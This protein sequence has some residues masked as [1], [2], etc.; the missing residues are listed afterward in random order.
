MYMPTRR[1]HGPNRSLRAY[2]L[3]CSRNQRSVKPLLQKVLFLYTKNVFVPLDMLLSLT[4]SLVDIGVL[5]RRL[6][7]PV[8]GVG[9]SVSAA[10]SAVVASTQLSIST[11]PSLSPSLTEQPAISSALATATLTPNLGNPGNI[12]SYP[13]C[14]VRAATKLSLISFQFATADIY[15]SLSKFVTTR[16]WLFQR[17]SMHPTVI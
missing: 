12:L 9:A 7:A 11:T 2:Q 1:V 5:S 6:C 13:L 10:A 8:G 16:L 17:L 15:I 14:A 4:S 3:Q